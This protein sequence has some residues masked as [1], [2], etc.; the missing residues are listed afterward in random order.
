MMMF[1]KSLLTAG[2]LA[3][4]FVAHAASAQQF[5]TRPV[6]II[7]PFSAGSGPDTSLRLVTDKL[8]RAWG[9][10][11]RVENRPGAN[12]FIAIEAAKRAEPDGYTLL[13]MD[14]AQAAAHPHLYRNLP[15]EPVKDFD[16]IA[17]LLR[18]YFFVVVPAESKWQSIADL[19]ADAK[20]K[21]GGLTYGSWH[22]GSPGHL[23]AAQLEAA[24]GTEMTHVPFKEFAQLYA[25]VGNNDVAWAFGSAAS[26]GPLYQAGKIKFLAAAAPKRIPGYTDI[27]TVA[28]SGGPANFE[29]GGWIGLFAPRGTP[30]NV[31]T[32]INQDITNALSQPDVRE[33]YAVFGYEHFQ[34]TPAE[35]TK[36]INEDSRRYADIIQRSRISLD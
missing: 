2:A 18:S 25:A 20:S 34:L 9:Q 11:V 17:P 29:L 35:M 12:G 16:P 4:A 36:L 7:T 21:R 33:R 10:Q 28:E 15:Y 24:T 5:P 32:R 31:I 13:Q 8:T 30:A 3:F 23:G 19:I 26:A 6:K 27:P 1:A 22:I 14:S